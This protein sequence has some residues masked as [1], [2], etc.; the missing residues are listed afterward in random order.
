[1]ESVGTLVDFFT[2]YGY[3]V[4]LVATVIDATGFPFPGRVLLIA[5]GSLAASGR[6]NLALLIAA[7]ALGAIIGDHLWYLSG[8]FGGT[9]LLSLYCRL[10]LGSGR[11]VERTTD[12][13]TRYGAWAI[14]IGRF[15][16]GVRIFAAPLAGSGGMRYPTFLACE[17]GG[18]VV[19]SSLFV[20]LGWLVGDRWITAAD[21]VGGAALA[22]G[23]VAVLAAGVV[24]VG[25]L[26]R[27][28]RH[29]AAPATGA[30]AWRRAA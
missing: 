4:V 2:R 3:V 28:A 30:P 22:L 12:Y 24:L 14:V 25:R 7:G 16:A 20:L 10:S 15:V 23:L 8:R 5:T 17:V 26:R 6:L 29:G 19:W 11:C 18:A 27:R 1:M 13:F 21:R 9:R